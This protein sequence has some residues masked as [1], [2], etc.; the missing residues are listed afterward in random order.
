MRTLNLLLELTFFLVFFFFVFLQLEF[1][2]L[3]DGH[4]ALFGL[5]F[6]ELFHYDVFEDVAGV[7][8]V[9][10]LGSTTFTIDG[11]F[12]QEFVFLLCVHWWQMFLKPSAIIFLLDFVSDP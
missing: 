4:L 7:Q 1:N 9:S 6:Q 2:A 11:V 8:V 12:E 5:D 3:F 10:E